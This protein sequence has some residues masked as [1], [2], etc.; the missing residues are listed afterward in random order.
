MFFGVE[1]VARYV[2]GANAVTH[3]AREGARWAIAVNNIPSGQATACN[4]SLAGLQNAVT[5]SAQGLGGSLTTTATEDPSSPA[6]W[7]QVTV[8]WQYTPAA[9]AFGLRPTAVSSA[10]RE[11]YN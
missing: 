10:A 6:A 1:E 7:C 2:Y 8:T 5:R 3:A 4:S 9:G 11:Y